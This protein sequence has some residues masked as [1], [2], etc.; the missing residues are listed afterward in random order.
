MPPKPQK[1]LA[2]KIIKASVI[3]GIANILLKFTGLIY[4]KCA[5]HFLSSAEYSAIIVI[6]MGGIINE[7]FLSG[8]ELIRPTLMTTFTKEMKD[9]DE[10]AAWDL[11]NV[12]ISFQSLILIII[13][14]T[15]MCFPDFYISVFTQLKPPVLEPVA[16]PVGTPETA[17]EFIAYKKLLDSYQIYRCLRLGLPII[18]PALLFLSLGTTTYVMLNGYKKFFMAAFGDASTKICCIIG[19][20]VGAFLHMGVKALFFA[21]LV[22]AVAKVVT[23]LLALFPKLKY[24]RISFNWKNPAF[25]TM[26]LLMLPLIAGV[27]FA[28]VRDIFNNI[29]ILTGGYITDQQDVLKAN[30]LGRKLFATI[31][32]MV[33]YA[34]QIALFPFLCDLANSDDKRKLGEVISNCCKMLLSIFVPAA[35]TLAIIGIPLTVLIFQGGETNVQV[36]ALG[37]ISTICYCFVLPAAAIESVLMQ[38][39]FAERKTIAV[40]AI[41]LSTSFISVIIS[42]V[43]IVHIGV[44]PKGALMTVALGFVIAK[45]LKSIMLIINLRRSTPIFPAKDLFVFLPKLIVLT[46]LAGV[47]AFGASRLCEKIVPD[48]LAKTMKTVQLQAEAHAETAVEEKAL[49]PADDPSAAAED[50]AQQSKPKKAK[51]FSNIS[52]IRI[53]IRIAATMAAAGV[54]FIIGSFLLKLQE[55]KQMLEWTLGKAFA[56]LKKKAA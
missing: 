4:T 17:A 26:L 44:S 9:K 49:P 46:A 20:I 34:L 40:T 41:G 27:V 23:H 18:A 38:G 19:L 39:S 8:E 50:A 12:T 42:Y 30:D 15:I 2:D 33:P 53:A 51:L 13:C 36:A 28:K 16:P 5:T 47:C 14:A 6:A 11:A 55:S 54:A 24:L 22:G 21:I 56:K 37:G 10:K 48:G 43:F 35:I 25:R 32:W 52:R 45:F 7:L 31:Q 3:V 1:S 29:Y